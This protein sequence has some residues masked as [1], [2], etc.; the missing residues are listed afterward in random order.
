MSPANARRWRIRAVIGWAGETATAGG[1]TR[2]L[3]IV[4]VSPAFAR[5]WL[6]QA[7]VDFLER[8]LYA[9]LA[10]WDDALA[11]GQAVT[12]AGP[13]LTALRVFEVRAGDATVARLALAATG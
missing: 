9:V 8:P 10:P 6:P 1:W 4:P 11:A 3:A 7:D 2:R 5:N 12:W 13:A